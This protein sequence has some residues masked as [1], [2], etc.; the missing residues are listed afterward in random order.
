[1]LSLS[2]GALMAIHT[3]LAIT[4]WSVKWSVLQ[5]LVCKS[6]FF[7]IVMAEPRQITSYH[8]ILFLPWDYCENVCLTFVTNKQISWS[9]RSI[10]K[11]FIWVFK[12]LR[13][14]MIYWIAIYT[15]CE[16]VECPPTPNTSTLSLSVAAF[17]VRGSVFGRMWY[18]SYDKLTHNWVTNCICDT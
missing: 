18:Y 5:P 15:V 12:L 7:K 1:M 17:S 4:Q 16:W 8:K 9:K 3:G 10:G 13:L 11:H 6:V 14:N 2:S